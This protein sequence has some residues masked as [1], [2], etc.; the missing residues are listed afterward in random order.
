MRIHH[1][2]CGCM[3]PVGGALFDGVSR[4]LF[5]HLV[6]HCLLLETERQGLVLVDTGFGREDVAHP[7]QRLSGFFRALNNIRYRESLCA[8][9]QIELLGF[10]A[11]DVRHIILT[12][13]DFDHAGGISDFPSAKI[14][15]LQHELDYM[16]QRNATWLNR[17]RYRPQQWRTHDGWRGYPSQGERWFG[18][19]AVR[20]LDDFNDDI[21]FVP[22]PGHTPGHSGVA[23]R[24]AGGWLL[25]GGDAW[26]YR[27]EM[28]HTERHCTPGL[29]AYQRLMC[30]DVAAWRHNQQRLR[31]LSLE[32]ASTI[33][34]FCS[35]DARELAQC[36]SAP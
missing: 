13:L 17:Q 19:D 5:A 4:G 27:D 2:N 34:L 25:H 12:H 20:A 9:T 7:A 10:R 23:I 15:L 1:L 29:R 31:A 6:C 14:H 36:Q 3:C 30:S 8:K 22:L 18:F 35:H 28:R 32:H 26:F 16:S 21:L 11:A 33:Q 24:H